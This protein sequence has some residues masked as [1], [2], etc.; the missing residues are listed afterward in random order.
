MKKKTMVK[1]IDS[2]FVKMG[3]RGGG[4]VI[5]G[6]IGKMSFF[7]FVKTSKIGIIGGGGGFIGIVCM[8]SNT[9][10]LCKIFILDCDYARLENARLF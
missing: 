5:I 4:V 7:D 2:M 8:V 3:G 6:G 10:V 1:Q 9:I